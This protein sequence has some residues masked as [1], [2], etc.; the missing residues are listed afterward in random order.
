MKIGIYG[1]SFNPPHNMHL[2]MATELLKRQ[3]VD[4]VIFVPTGNKYPKQ[5]LTTG[6]DRFEMISLMIQDLPNLEVSD[7]EL[8]QELIYTYQTLTYFKELY[9]DDEIYFVLASELLKEITTWKNYNDILNQ[10]KILVT[11]RDQDKKEDLANIN[12]PNKENIV[13]T[14]IELDSLSSTE[15]RQAVKNKDYEFLETNLNQKVLKYIKQKGI[16]GGL[17]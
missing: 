7:Y 11:L 9:S 14:N 4:K 1:G 12:L 8:K 6:K 3:L 5:D 13:Y 2:K 15:I 16:Y 17:C 10:F